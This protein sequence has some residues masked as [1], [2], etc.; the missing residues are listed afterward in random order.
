MNSDEE[1]AYIFNK[2]DLWVSSSV[3]SGT[4]V[5]VMAILI[6]IT[7]SN[8]LIPIDIIFYTV[9]AFSILTIISLSRWYSW[10]KKAHKGIGSRDWMGSSF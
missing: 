3:I 8:D 1:L 10:H 4:L 6:P 9:A 2:R 5:C 7:R